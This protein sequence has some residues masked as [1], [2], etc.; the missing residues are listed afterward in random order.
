MPHYARPFLKPLDLHKQKE[1][2]CSPLFVS[3]VV[4]SVNGTATMKFKVMIG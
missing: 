4:S 3:L 2:G 1:V